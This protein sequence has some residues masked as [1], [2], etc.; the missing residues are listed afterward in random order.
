MKLNSVVNRYIFKE[1]IPPFAMN[2]LFFIFVFLMRQ[3]LEI[4]NVIVN[5]QVSLTAFLLMLTYSMPY[6]LAYIIPMSVMMSVLL[7]FLRLSSDNEIVALKASGISI[8][9]LLPPVIVFSLFSALLTGYMAIYG[10]PWGQQSYKQMAL[11]VVQS[12][13]NVGLKERQFN[14][15]FDG[16]MFYVSKIDFKDNSLG[17]IYI[18]DQRNARFSTTIVSPKGRIFNGEDR[19]SFILSLY[20]GVINQVNLESRAVHSTRFDTYDLQLDLKNA[21]KNISKKKI[22]EKDMRIEELIAFLKTAKTKSKKYY[23]VWIELHKKFSIPFACIALGILAVPLGVQSS[24]TRKSAGLGI[25]LIA[26]LIY[27]LLLS[28]GLVLSEAGKISPVLGMWMPNIIMG[29]L[30][31]YL[32]VRTANDNPV[33]IFNRMNQFA[34]KIIRNFFRIRHTD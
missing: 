17:D 27:Y 14:D 11:N 5:Y 16:V 28:A 31:I 20:N 18:E 33:E 7:T 13:F 10:I 21:V 22:K 6:F 8:Y 30:G 12:N 34:G 23:S 32:L 29:G 1:L 9:R 24:S 19:L 15:S 26:F 4:T 3:I 25:G 2:L